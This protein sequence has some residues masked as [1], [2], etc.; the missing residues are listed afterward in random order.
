[1]TQDGDSGCSSHR[2]LYF[3]GMTFRK[4]LSGGDPGNISHGADIFQWHAGPVVDCLAGKI[5]IVVV[6]E[7]FSGERRGTTNIYQSL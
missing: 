1:M 5:N 7:K 6:L 2:V 3:S 4:K